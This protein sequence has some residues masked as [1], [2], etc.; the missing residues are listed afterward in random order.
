MIGLFQENGPCHFV[1]SATEP[2]LNPYSF[3]EYANMLYVD[4]PIGVGFSYGT[5]QRYPARLSKAQSA[6]NTFILLPEQLH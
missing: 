3:N 4:Q 5:G 6:S 1:G 2:T